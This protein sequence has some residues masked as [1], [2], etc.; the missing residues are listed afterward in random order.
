MPYLHTP[1]LS[2]SFPAVGGWHLGDFPHPW[3]DTQEIISQPVAWGLK[4]SEFSVVC[5]WR[6]PGQQ[7]VSGG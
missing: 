1:H 4:G 7:K 3:H 6:E 5:V 2:C